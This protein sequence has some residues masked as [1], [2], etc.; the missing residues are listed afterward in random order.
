[1]QSQEVTSNFR[2]QQTINGL[3][4]P[5]SAQRFFAEGISIYDREVERFLH[6]QH[7]SGEDILEISEELLRLKQRYRRE[8]LRGGHQTNPDLDRDDADSLG[9]SQH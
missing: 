2:I 3:F 7:F 9:D 8:P 6:R 4:Y 5:T 1:M